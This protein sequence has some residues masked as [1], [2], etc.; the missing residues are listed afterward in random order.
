[1]APSC[2]TGGSLT[3]HKEKPFR[4]EFKGWDRVKCI[5]LFT[6][7]HQIGFFCLFFLQLCPYF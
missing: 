3:T 5:L 6:L 1:M 7:G 2:L 4:C